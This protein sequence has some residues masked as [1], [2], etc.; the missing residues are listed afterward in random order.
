MSAT[1]STNASKIGAR[2]ESRKK[3]SKAF[4][5]PMI[6]ALIPFAPPLLTY[7][8]SA[9][10]GIKKAYHLSQESDLAAP[11]EIDSR[12]SCSEIKKEGFQNNLCLGIG[13]EFDSFK[14]YQHQLEEKIGPLTPEQRK[15]LFIDL[16]PKMTSIGLTD[17]MASRH[18]IYA[19]QTGVGKTEAM[20][21][22]LKQQIE[23]GGG[24]LIFLAKGEESEA[25]R[26]YEMCRDADRE[27]AFRY[28]N[29]ENQDV[30]HT[31]S[32][33]VGGNLRELT[34]TATKLQEEGGEP[35]FA[36]V[37]YAGLSA[38]I[39]LLSR[40]KKQHPFNFRDLSSV[41]SDIEL[42][43]TL[44]NTMSEETED[45]RIDKQFIYNFINTFVTFN[46]KGDKVFNKHKWETQF[47][48]IQAALVPFV[49]SMYGSLVNS[50]SP[51]I[52]L[53]RSIINNEIIVVSIS[54][55]ADTKGAAIFGQ[56][57][58]AD[59]G[60]AIGQIQKRSNQPMIPFYVWLDEYNSIKH[61]HHQ[62]L[63]QLGR[64]GNI[65]LNISVQSI[66]FLK[67]LSQEFAMN[68]ASQCWTTIIYDVK[69]SDTRQFAIDLAGTV[70]RQYRQDNESTSTGISHE[71]S[72]G[73][74]Y[75]NR[76][77]SK[78]RSTGYKEVREEMLQPQ[79]FM[80]DRGDALIIG[81]YETY[82]VRMPLVNFA[83]PVAPT[84][85]KS[86]LH[87]VDDG[88]APGLNLFAM[89]TGKNHLSMVN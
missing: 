89:S 6:S 14:S 22:A 20:R 44:H 2:S 80:L 42:F 76:N 43:A 36:A 30:S 55:L 27:H 85:T 40:Q 17:D 58:L 65:S 21:S 60:R 87:S 19:G 52:E 63:F 68:L 23:R 31:Y 33:F 29:F 3:A 48:G 49:T 38:A 11:A 82:V 25:A 4:K 5:L 46:N 83:R 74:M 26:I 35:F 12:Y 24:G 81:K 1:T 10:F 61:Q 45:E 73:G 41:F 70:L 88:K 7:A 18:V 51:D 56:L 64:S 53:E 66:N 39:I 67:E 15:N 32:P 13:M 71:S 54:S 59:L 28:L 77:T 69:D 50:Y 75:H 79:D 62:G 34:S 84:L 57:M 47:A 9:G 16:I 72:Q 86:M 8:I 78:S 37:S